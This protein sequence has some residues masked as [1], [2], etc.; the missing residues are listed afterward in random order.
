[1]GYFG[2]IV[3]APPTPPT[4][5]AGV[6]RQ[7]QFNDNGSFGADAGLAFDKTAKMLAVGGNVKAQGALAT[8][9]KTAPA[10]ADLAIGEIA[11][12]YDEPR[13]K[14]RLRAR[15]NAG[16]FWKGQVDLNRE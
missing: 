5:P 9:M 1:M 6:N 3:I 16:V 7:V 11:F 8:G 10:D 13:G 2:Q 12:W 15:D 4:P 14:V